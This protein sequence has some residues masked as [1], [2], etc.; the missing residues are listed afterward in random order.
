MARLFPLGRRQWLIATTLTAALG[1][2]VSTA[3]VPNAPAAAM[4]DP[5]DRRDDL[6]DRKADVN[7]RLHGA[8][9]DL[10][11]SSGQ[12]LAAARAL[13][14][15]QAQ[16]ATAQQNLARTRG[17]LSAAIE[18]DRVMQDRLQ[19][20]EARLEYAEQA[21]EDSRSDVR[22]AEDKL[23]SFIVTTYEYGSPSLTSLS[24]VLQGGEP[25]DFGRNMSLADS[26]V[27]AQSATI[28]QLQAKKT[29]SKVREQAVQR[30]RDQV[31]K[32]REEAAENLA[33]MKV[34]EA[35]AEEQTKQ[36]QAL[37]AE[38]QAAEQQAEQAKQI[39][40][41][42]IKTLEAKREKIKDH[43]ERIAER[44]SGPGI[45]VSNSGGWLSWP[46]TDTYITSPYGMRFHPILHYWKLHDGTDFGA[47][48]GTPVYAAASGTVISEYYDDAYGN[49]VTISHGNV[50]GVSLATSY[51]HLTSFV[52]GYGEHVERG[53]LIAYSGTTGWST[54]C[55][56]HF[57]VYE[58]GATVDPM[59]WL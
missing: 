2:L 12:L 11:E 18:L 19:E 37:V 56:L 54:G 24:L 21:L 25:S 44:L 16:L 38:R 57:M 49:R 17:Q 40:L 1:V 29:I 7:D 10:D 34:L 55:H 47:A 27:G 15:A 53:Q 32:R 59:T 9:R 50:N 14:A 23:S 46:V 5:D 39:D 41:A 45:Q 20:A 26:V 31:A 6:K 42:R 33:R 51:N 52:A 48:C 3:A 58:N 35:Q 30:L 13:N 8:H 4:S 22:S 43:L 36:V 28:D